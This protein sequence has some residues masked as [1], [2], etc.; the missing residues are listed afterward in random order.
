MVFGEVRRCVTNDAYEIAE[1]IITPWLCLAQ[2]LFGR[3]AEK[4][5]H[6]DAANARRSSQ[7]LMQAPRK[8]DL[9][10]DFARGHAL[11]LV[12]IQH[13]VNGCCISPR[14]HAGQTTACA[15]VGLSRKPI[16]WTLGC[17]RRPRW[18]P[19]A[20]AAWRSEERR[21]GKECRL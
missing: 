2:G 20:R 11:R 9:R 15:A 4:M 1:W 8:V 17:V 18:W 19:A 21:V 16:S 7:R 12:D 5:R 6:R 14:L 13:S 10:S 3:F